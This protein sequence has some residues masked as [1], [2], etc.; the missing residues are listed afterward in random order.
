MVLPR[1]TRSTHPLPCDPTTTRSAS[2]A[3]A[4]S[5]MVRLGVPQ[6]TWGSA[7]TSIAAWSTVFA[8][9]A[10]AACRCF[11]S[12]IWTATSGMGGNG[13]TTWSARS[14]APNSAAKRA[15]AASVGAAA[16]DRSVAASTRPM[17]P[18]QAAVTRSGTSMVRTAWC[19]VLPPNHLTGA[20]WCLPPNTRSPAPSSRTAWPSTQAGFPSR[21]SIRSRLSGGA[22]PLRASAT[23]CL[24]SDATLAA[25]WSASIPA[26]TFGRARVT[27]TRRQPTCAASATA[28]AIAAARAPS[29]EASTPATTGFHVI[30]SAPVWSRPR[31]CAAP[32]GAGILR[33]P[34]SLRLRPRTRQEPEAGPVKSHSGRFHCSLMRLCVVC[35]WSSAR[36]ATA[37]TPQEGGAGVRDAA[38]ILKGSRIGRRQGERD[39]QARN[40]M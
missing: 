26:G 37:G 12:S 5:Q 20:A 15:A 17:R 32:R 40:P 19:T 7:A 34:T 27:C 14:S 16:S 3:A 30:D 9:S 21:T 22:F 1:S 39:R 31:R 8:N 35:L 36:V 6:R 33:A 18:R 24:A 29:R 13:S 38:E 10:S 4:S 23:C 11:C 28:Q 25:A 2:H